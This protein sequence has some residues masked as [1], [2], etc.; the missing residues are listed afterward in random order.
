M[1]YNYHECITDE[2]YSPP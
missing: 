2:K 1:R